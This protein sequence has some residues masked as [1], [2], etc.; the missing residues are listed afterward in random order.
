MSPWQIPQTQASD[1]GPDKFL[2]LIANLVK[3]PANLPVDAL[4]EDNLK[5]CSLYRMDLVDSSAL[6]VEHHAI[7][8]FPREG[9]IPG[10]IQGDLIFLFDF[11]ARMGEALRQ[12]AV[13]GQ[14]Q[15]AFRLGIEPADIKEAREFRRQEIENSVAR[16]R[17]GT[18]RNKTSR[19]I[20]DNVERAFSAD[21]FAADFDVVVLRGLRAE[22]SANPAVDRDATLS[23]QLVAMPPRADTGGG[24]KTV[25]AHVGK[26]TVA[27]PLC[28][29][30]RGTAT[31]RLA[32]ALVRRPA[33]S[34]EDR[35]LS[36]LP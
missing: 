10:M 7:D 28:R 9:R 1:P 14:D 5:A 15:Q 36:C 35:L 26:G 6:S 4:P 21:K 32:T 8:Q 17:I 16:I 25:Q 27:A 12:V 2:H 3:H 33:S 11:V 29:G 20:E 22:I 34:S 19:L 18:R 13:V 30:E 31:E 23:N 24:E